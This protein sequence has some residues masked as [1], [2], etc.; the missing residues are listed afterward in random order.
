VVFS[1]RSLDSLLSPL[2]FPTAREVALTTGFCS[3]GGHLPFLSPGA[4]VSDPFFNFLPV[5]AN[6]PLA[7]NT[8]PLRSCRDRLLSG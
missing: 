1:I 3:S 4:K 5:I 6:S 2:W 8:D 7:F